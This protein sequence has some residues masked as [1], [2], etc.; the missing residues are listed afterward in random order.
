METTTRQTA[1]YAALAALALVA[2]GCAGVAPE[3]VDTM[4]ARRVATAPVL[5]V[6]VGIG[7]RMMY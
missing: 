7:V 1:T 2:G 5:F 6:G 3:E 4:R